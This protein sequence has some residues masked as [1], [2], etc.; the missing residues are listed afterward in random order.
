MIKFSSIEADGGIAMPVFDGLPVSKRLYDKLI[1]EGC[2]TWNDARQLRRPI[3]GMRVG[4]KTSQEL[5]N[6]LLDHAYEEYVRYYP[7]NY[8]ATVSEAAQRRQRARA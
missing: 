2:R 4:A 7:K 3:S 1:A 5:E 6:C 8:W